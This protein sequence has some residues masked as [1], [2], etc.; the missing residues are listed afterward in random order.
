MRYLRL[1][2]GSSIELLVD[3]SVFG[4][5]LVSLL[6]SFYY[7]AWRVGSGERRGEVDGGGWGGS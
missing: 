6:S 7:M 1:R 5:R 4:C 3:A 2:D